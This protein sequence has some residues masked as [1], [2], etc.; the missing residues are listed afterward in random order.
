MTR[1][2]AA[3]LAQVIPVVALALGL[4]IRSMASRIRAAKKPV[5]NWRGMLLIY[6]CVA[7]FVLACA[8]IRVLAVVA[9]DTFIRSWTLMLIFAIIVAFM[10]PAFDALSEVLPMKR[11]DIRHL[12][13]PRKRPLILLGYAA[14]ALTLFGVL[15]VLATIP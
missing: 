10:A 8:E 15:A 12:R 9:G 6:M 3:L 13:D 1:D 2:Y 11:G 14:L 5:R 4:E 7:L